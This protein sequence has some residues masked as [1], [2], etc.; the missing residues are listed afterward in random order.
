[1]KQIDGKCFDSAETFRGVLSALVHRPHELL[2]GRW[3]WKSAVLSSICRGLIFLGVN[4]G[5]G[6]DAASGAMLAEFVYRASTAGFAGALTQAF[7]AARPRWAAAVAI[8]LCSHLIE[9]LIHW[10]RGTPNL[11]LSIGASLVFTVIST[12]FNLH[13]MRRGVLLVGRGSQSVAA[14]MRALPMVIVTFMSSG[15]GLL[16]APAPERGE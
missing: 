13:A 6:W 2:V 14:D 8:P 9:F 11:R 3:N 15:F 12:L 7:R 10:L 1:V 5:A 16:A 4:L